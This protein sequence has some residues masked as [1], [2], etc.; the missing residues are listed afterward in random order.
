MAGKL[1]HLS[2]LP[3]LVS[4]KGGAWEGVTETQLVTS[5]RK[6]LQI[7]ALTVRTR[8]RRLLMDD[9]DTVRRDDAGSLLTHHRHRL[10]YNKQHH[11]SLHG[12]TLP[13]VC[14]IPATCSRGVPDW[15]RLHFHMCF[16]GHHMA[17]SELFSLTLHW[18]RGT[19]ALGPA[20]WSCTSSFTGTRWCLLPVH[21]LL[22]HHDSRVEQVQ[23]GLQDPGAENT[24]SLS[25]PSRESS[26]T[27][28]RVSA[29]HSATPNFEAGKRNPATVPENR[30]RA[31]WR[32]A[33][34]SIIVT[35]DRAAFLKW[36]QAFSRSRH[37]FE[38]ELI[39]L[40]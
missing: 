39:L 15:Q 1:F 10:R 21:P 37:G 16:H 36:P 18:S 23:Q 25:G 30:T 20:A 35:H 19:I 27:P 14:L 17:R 8:R 3:F 33:L 11:Q 38:W 31:T 4:A 9:G 29:S 34:L 7:P 32:T 26:P 28:E 13:S 5:P 6:G 22:S 2:E 24:S 12:S 40:S